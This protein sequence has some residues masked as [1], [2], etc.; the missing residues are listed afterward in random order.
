MPQ[1]VKAKYATANSSSNGIDRNKGG[2]SKVCD[3]LLLNCV[4]LHLFPLECLHTFQIPTPWYVQLLKCICSKYNSESEH[5]VTLASRIE[6]VWIAQFLFKQEPGQQL[7]AGEHQQ[8]GQNQQGGE[9]HGAGQQQQGGH[10]HQQANTSA[11]VSYNVK[12]LVGVNVAP[13]FPFSVDEEP[14][15][16]IC[17]GLED[18]LAKL[19]GFHSTLADLL[20]QTSAGTSCA[21]PPGFS[22]LVQYVD[23]L[24]NMNAIQ[25]V[26]PSAVYAS[27]LGGAPNF[28]VCDLSVAEVVYLGR[29]SLLLRLPGADNVFKVA[30]E[31]TIT[32]ELSFHKVIDRVVCEGLRHLT[33]MGHGMVL[34]AGDGLGFL[35]LEHW[36]QPVSASAL[37]SAATFEK[38]WGQVNICSCAA[39][40]LVGVNLND[41]CSLLQAEAAICTLHTNH[42]LHRDVKPDN[43]LIHD[44]TL[45]LND[46][47]VSC[48]EHEQE[49]R[50]HSPVGTSSFW[51]PRY[52]VPVH[53][54]AYDHD[55]DW[56]GL[57]LTFAF[58]LGF[59]TAPKW[60]LDIIANKLG[61]VRALVAA[62][63]APEALKARIGP[64]ITRVAS[65]LPMVT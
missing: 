55:D 25:Q 5:L 17:R 51:S 9:Q 12:D 36:C 14:S 31:V 2:L 56:I 49:L 52:D 38:W 23:A 20:C 22:L 54:W 48:F 58:W 33:A 24:C 15:G 6:A 18:A 26:K 50:V 62:R 29:K 44:G 32:R 40:V 10:R 13:Y 35:L 65:S 60:S 19:L 57:A 39:N 53:G 64:V 3:A 42:V 16:V 21:P 59:Y 43:F 37:Q 4:T 46:F 63:G 11:S 30:T 61:A 28:A 7:E 8:G 41:A 1:E 45:Q 47:D 34:G 27:S